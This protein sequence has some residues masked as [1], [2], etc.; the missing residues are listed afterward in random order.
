MSITTDSAPS[1]SG[2]APTAER[3]AHLAALR[4][5][6]AVWFTEVEH[7][8]LAFQTSLTDH[9][10]AIVEDDLY[11]EAQWKAPRVTNQIRRLHAECFKLD[12]LTAMSLSAVHASGATSGSVMGCLDQLLRLAARHESRALAIDHEAFCVDIGGQG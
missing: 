10:R 4:S 7:E 6:E 8:L 2:L 9:T 5:D 11:H 12:E 3:L 1:V